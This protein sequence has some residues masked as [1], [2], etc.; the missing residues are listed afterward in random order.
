[1]TFPTVHLNGTSARDLLNDVCKQL[2]A[3][4]AAL[5]VMAATGPNAR[6]YYP[7]GSMA[8]PLARQ[9]HSDR[10]DKIR[11]VIAEVGQTAEY[12]AERV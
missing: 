5:E 10:M 8:F 4:N 12:L 2:N 7:Q 11:M 1:M 6:D 3:L 9:E